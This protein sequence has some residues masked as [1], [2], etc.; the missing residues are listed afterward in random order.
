MQRIKGDAIK[1][2]AYNRAQK[3]AHQSLST[4]NAHSEAKKIEADI[5]SKIIS[6]N[7]KNRLEASKL[8]SQA[9]SIE[10]DAESAQSANLDPKRK[11]EERM[12][13][14]ENLKQIAALNKMMITGKNAEELLGYFKDTNDMVFQQE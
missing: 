14:A 2:Q 13:L 6:I 9:L 11:H 7:A 8:K 4:A 1:S 12:A 10:A 5:K 3:T